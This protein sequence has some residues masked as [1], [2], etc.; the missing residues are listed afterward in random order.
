MQRLALEFTL[1]ALLIAAAAGAVLA[2]L[3]IRAAAAQHAVWTGVVAA[4][5]LLPFWIAW[6]PKASLPVFPSPGGPAV[7]MRAAPV[8]L[9]DPA[10]PLEVSEAPATKPPVWS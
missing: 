4:M 9:V 8:S 6:G 1:R 2:V 7:V 5:L 10:T 3:R